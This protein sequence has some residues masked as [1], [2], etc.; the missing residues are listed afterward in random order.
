MEN[1]YTYTARSATDPEKVVTFTLRGKRM[2]V[3]SGVPVE[4]AARLIELAAKEEDVE[5]REGEPSEADEPQLWLKPM[6]I[7]LVERGTNA[8][9]VIDVDARATGAGY[10][11]VRGWIRVGGL[12]LTPV[13]LLDGMVDNPDAALAFVE[14]L[15]RRKDAYAE[16]P[17]VLNFLDYWATWLV[18]GSVLVTF[19]SHWRKRH[20]D[21]DA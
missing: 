17:A 15:A 18:L 21:A 20:D 13:I 5:E 11:W 16:G 7:S 6:A 4:Q 19:F 2:S 8:L 10:L 1:T 9:R 12:R 3:G 14:E